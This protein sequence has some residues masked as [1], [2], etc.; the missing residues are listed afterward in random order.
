M[1]NVL[2]Y[3]EKRALEMPG[4]VAVKDDHQSCTYAELM[5]RAK[6]IGTEVAAHTEV[7]TS[8]VVFMEKSVIA[9]ASFLG[10]TY[11][12]CFYTL[13]DP[14][15]PKERLEQIL[16]ILAPKMILTTPDYREKL[17]GL[18]YDGVVWDVNTV[19]DAVSE[20][21]LQAIR[22]RATDTDPLYCNFTSGS[23]GTPKGVLVS[24]GAV[25]DFIEQ[26]V[27][28]T[29]IREDDVIANQAPFDF[30]VS[31]KDIY[32]CLKTGATLVIIPKS[33]FTFPMAV[34]DRLCENQVTVLIWAVSAMCLVSRMHGFQYKIPE[35]IRMVMF[36]GEQMPIKQLNIWRGVYPDAT[37]INLY[38]PTEITCNCMYYIL[39]REYREDEKL[40]LG[41]AFANEKVFLLDEEDKPVTEPGKQG[42]ICVAG[43]TLALG[44]YR[45]PEATARSFTQNP[46]NQDY[47]ERIYRTG[48]NAY[49]DD[50]G[51]MFFSGRMDF[52]IKHMGHRIELEEIETLVNALPGVDQACVFFDDEKNKIVAC[53]VGDGEKRSL[54]D[55]M[56][57]K[58]PEFM[59]PNKWIRTD[60]LPLT[61]NGKTDRKKM[62]QAYIQGAYHG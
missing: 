31:V 42:Q 37:F 49:Y 44:Y 7:R 56:K 47:P 58:V 62:K 22:D 33:C 19:T 55:G 50:N 34:L 1:I 51:E 52:Q 2:S 45:N 6:A 17:D 13:L 8:V 27:L 3:L 23:T 46:L 20:D 26:F 40:P 43:T 14:D 16:D 59:V 54:I 39:D 15:F 38:G 25:I 4:K 29:G 10:I 18:A 21:V 35:Q 57:Q 5:K 24:H 12:G 60:S 32:S 41:R 48:D 61:K 30:D 53:Y 36:S 11:A 9:L 28:T